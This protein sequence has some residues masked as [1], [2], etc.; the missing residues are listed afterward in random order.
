MIPTTLIGYVQSLAR[1]PILGELVAWTEGKMPALKRANSIANYRS[2]LAHGQTYVLKKDAA[3][4]VLARLKQSKK[5][6]AEKR[7]DADSRVKA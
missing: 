2:K 7:A 5:R 3:D 6:R 1:I 4:A